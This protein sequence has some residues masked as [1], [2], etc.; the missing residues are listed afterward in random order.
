MKLLFILILLMGQSLWAMTREQYRQEL[1]DLTRDGKVN[2]KALEE[3]IEM[4]ELDQQF[5]RAPSIVADSED[6]ILQLQNSLIEEFQPQ[7]EQSLGTCDQ[8]QC[9]TLSNEGARL[10]TAQ[11]EVCFPYTHCGFYKCMEEKYR[12]S[13]VGVHYFTKLAYPT[14]SAYVANLQKNKFTQKG[15]EWIYNVM[16]CLQK[17][18]VQECDLNNNCQQPSQKEVCDH[19]TDYT[20]SFHP[21]CYINSG[22]GVCHLPLKDQINIWKTV[23]PYLTDR[24]RVEAFKVVAYCLK[25]K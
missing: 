3:K 4:F 11:K 6:I 9:L 18:L 2:I 25:N 22:V 14:C 20:L 10:R 12:C 15:V 24:E 17:G 8:A 5:N 19:I 7:L 16:V 23:G 21:S 13:D 1:E